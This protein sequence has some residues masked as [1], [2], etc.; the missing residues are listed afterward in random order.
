MKK[1]LNFA[2]RATISSLAGLGVG[3]ILISAPTPIGVSPCQASDH[4]FCLSEPDA[5]RIVVELELLAYCRGE[6][7]PACEYVVSRQDN[8][9]SA[10]KSKAEADEKA[11][12]S[13]KKAKEGGSWWERAKDT[14]L[15]V[16]VGVVL[17][18]VLVL[19]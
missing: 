5:G 14:A 11:L 4:P 15:K 10:M 18:I 1:S 8:V 17:G 9:I 13:C 19:I 2:L 6:A 7:L 12:D 3:L 16:G